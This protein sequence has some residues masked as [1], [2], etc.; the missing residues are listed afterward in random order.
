MLFLAL[1]VVGLTAPRAQAGAP[2][3]PDIVEQISHMQIQNEHQREMLRFSTGHINLGNGPLQV[4]G[5]GQIAPCVIE[6]IAYEQCTIS[7]QEILD[8]NGNIV[9]TNPAGTALYHPEHNHWHQD[10]VALFEIRSGSLSGPV[11]GSSVKTT[12]CL[13]DNDATDFPA[14]VRRRVYFECNDELQGISVGWGDSY[15]QATP[16]Q[17]LDV[18]GIPEGIYYLVHEA[19]PQNHWLETDE[20][21][22]LAWVKFSFSRKGA[23][24][25]ISILDR[26]PCSGAAC[27]SS[28]NP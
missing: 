26:S 20:N 2:L 25:R 14:R 23:N 17:E 13:V 21:N 10:S 1:T 7:T 3:Y 9:Q 24:P 6:G 22:N 12:F 16:G 18:T 5:G 8:S 19:D 4:R 15:N 11:V 28:S 27:G